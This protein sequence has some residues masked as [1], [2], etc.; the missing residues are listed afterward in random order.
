MIWVFDSWFWWLQTLKYLKKL[1]PS[2]DYVFLADSKNIPYWEKD[3]TRIQNRTFKC[4]DWLFSKWS[5]AIV[6]ACNTSSAYSIRKR[7]SMYPEKKVLS[8]TIP[9]IEKAIS[10]WYKNIS[11][12]ATNA[13]IISWIYN[14]LF[15]RIWDWTCSLQWISATGIVDLI[16]SWYQDWELL[17]RVIKKHTDKIN[18]NV[19]CVILWCTHFPIVFDIR[20]RFHQWPYIDPW[21]ESAISLNSY[22]DRHPE[23]YHKITKSWKVNLFTTWDRDVFE[24]I[25][26]NIWWSKITAESVNI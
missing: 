18:S 20:Q 19:E 14:D 16:E 10:M 11:I 2:F 4:L 9:G 22:L 24:K 17:E 21:Y 7:Q 8:I 5:V 1:Y 13:T 26:Q 23:L 15:D 3:P 6:L 25:G 12:L